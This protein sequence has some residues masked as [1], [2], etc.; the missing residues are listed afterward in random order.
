MTA[1][2]IR[3]RSK[4]VQWVVGERLLQCHGCGAKRTISNEQ[5]TDTCPFCGSR[6]VIETDALDTFQQPQGILPFALPEQQALA[7]VQEALKGIDERFRNL[8]NANRVKRTRVEGVFLPFWVY[9]AVVEVRRTTI[10]TRGYYDRNQPK[11]ANPYRT[12]QI[13]EMMNNVLVCAVHS[14][15]R[16]MTAQLGKYRL[17]RVV[18]YDPQMIAQHAA[19]L[20]SIE[21]DKAAMDAHEIISTTLRSKYSVATGSSEVKVNVTSLIKQ[22]RF[23]LLLLPVYSVTLFEEDG[24]VRPVLVNGQTGKVVLGKAKKQRRN[25][26][27]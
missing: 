24:E 23:Q 7:N 26:T 8:F 20:Y 3:Q 27:I 18:G 13:P 12:E 25:R 19:E 2:L 15:P 1:A 6:S 17:E 4:P 11:R 10:D 22:M 14:P 5:F 21:F 16:A 9:D